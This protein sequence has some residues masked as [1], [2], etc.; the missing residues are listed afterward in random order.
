MRRNRLERS[1]PPPA[2]R[3]FAPGRCSPAFAPRGGVLQRSNCHA[4]RHGYWLCMHDGSIGRFQD[5]KRKLIPP[6]SRSSLQT[7]TTYRP[8]KTDNP[9]FHTLSKANAARSFGTPWQPCGSVRT[10]TTRTRPRPHRAPV[11]IAGRSR[12]LTRPAQACRRDRSLR[13]GLEL[14]FHPAIDGERGCRGDATRVFEHR[15]IAADAHRVA[16]DRAQRTGIE[17]GSKGRILRTE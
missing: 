14:H 17:V 4:F 15:R 3:G 7:L 16:R 10:A 5:M 12:S 1:E 8:S 13:R 6:G 2:R 11:T 9:Q